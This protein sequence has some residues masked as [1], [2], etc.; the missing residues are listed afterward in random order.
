MVILDL[1]SGSGNWSQPYLEAG[2]EVLRIDLPQDVRLLEHIDK[3]VHGI[4]AAPPCTVFS[5]AGAWVQRTPDEIKLALGVVDS[6]L[7]AVA[8]YRPKWWALEN[9]KGRLTRFLG[10]PNYQFD[11]CDFGDPYTKRTYLW[12]QFVE[13]TKSP[14]PSAG[15]IIDQS[16]MKS[17]GSKR[18]RAKTPLGFAYAFFRGNP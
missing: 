11:P 17:S 9:P 2:Y 12:G 3:P 15:S 10:K 18:E 1:C 8:I 13:P 7:R 4:L 6:C 16:G 5:L 14:V